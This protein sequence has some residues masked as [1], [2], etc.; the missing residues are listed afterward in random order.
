MYWRAGYSKIG[1]SLAAEIAQTIT[2]ES[3]QFMYVGIFLVGSSE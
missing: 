1:I 2:K 3:V